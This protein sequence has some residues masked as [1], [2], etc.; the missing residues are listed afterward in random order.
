MSVETLL[1]W[2]IVGA[3]A[4]W[5]A[6]LVMGTNRRQGLLA[7]IVVGV[8]GGLLGGLILTTIGIRGLVT[9]INLGS[10]A[11]AFVGAIFLLFVLRIFGAAPRGRRYR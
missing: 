4:G 3:I 7:D 1:V 2:V 8:V 9:G 5:L 10:I 11:V 6:S